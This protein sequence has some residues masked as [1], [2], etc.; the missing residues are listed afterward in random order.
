MDHLAPSLQRFLW[1]LDQTVHVGGL[2][3]GYF[4][5]PF[6]LL[7]ALLVVSF[8][9]ERSAQR[10][11]RDLLWIPAIWIAIAL[12]GAWFWYDQQSLD[13]ARNPEWVRYPIDAA[14]PIILILD[15]YLVW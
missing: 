15:L 8:P 14:L 5:I 12:W 13:A 4:L 9:R 6:T 7:V 11:L 3:L 10:R 2:G 1:F